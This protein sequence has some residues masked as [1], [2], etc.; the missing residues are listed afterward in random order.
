MAQMPS[1]S[2]WTLW[3]IR[4][5]L[6]VWFSPTSRRVFSPFRLSNQAAHQPKTLYST[7]NS[8]SD[9]FC[10]CC[11]HTFSFKE[12]LKNN[13]YKFHWS[14]IFFEKDKKENKCVQLQI[15]CN[16]YEIG[17]TTER[18]EK[19]KKTSKLRQEV[20]TFKCSLHAAMR[21]CLLFWKIFWFQVGTT[22]PY[23]HSWKGEGLAN[24]KSGLA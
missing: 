21:K 7:D 5:W 16:D 4:I 3:S 9:Y 10:I 8:I 15:L 11:L 17:V 13:I 12:I 23:L 24:A 20:W 14:C 6:A 2:S 19:Q 18:R 1:F 22:E